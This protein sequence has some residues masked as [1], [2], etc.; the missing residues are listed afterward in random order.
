MSNRPSEVRSGPCVVTRVVWVA[1]CVLALGMAHAEAQETWAPVVVF[2]GVTKTIDGVTTPIAN[3]PVP[4]IDPI[5]SGWD[6]DTY[7]NPPFLFPNGFTEN[8]VTAEWIVADTYHGRLLRFATDQH[9]VH[10][11]GAFLG[12]I[13]TAIGGGTTF[14]YG[15]IVDDHGTIVLADIFA[16]AVKA[17]V[18]N[19]AGGY[20]GYEITSF[21]DALTDPF[22]PAAAFFSGP[23]RVAFVPDPVGGMDIAAGIGS[24]VVLD[25]YETKVYRMSVAGGVAS[26]AWSLDLAFGESADE[27]SC[28]GPGFFSFPTGLAADAAGNIYVSDP[29]NATTVT[30]Q[31]FD[32]AGAPIQ[33]IS[34]GLSTPWSL[35]IAPDQRLFVADT[36]NNR[37]A[38]FTKY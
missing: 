20:D 17:F 2:D 11:P 34:Q 36:G 21:T 9:P 38:V 31:V 8:P 16:A 7:G 18:P 32:S 25:A 33:I 6:Y 1:V 23:Y 14:P 15:P 19:L 28:A 26:P 24:L 4:A 10:E 29:L 3:G 12:A 22:N 30:I 37:I 27:C 13:P 5:F 35:T